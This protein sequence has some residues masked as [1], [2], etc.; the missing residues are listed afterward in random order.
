M[1]ERVTARGPLAWP[2]M[3]PG[4]ETAETVNG[5][6]RLIS[7]LSPADREAL[8]IWALA[9]AALMVLAWASA[10]V[11]RSGARRGPL[12]PFQQWAADWQQNV[13]AHGYFSAASQPHSVAFFPGFPLVLALVHLVLWD[14]VLSELVVSF[15]AGAVAVVALTRLA[16]TSRAAAVLV[17]MPAAVFLMVGYQESLFLA[18][19][20]PAWLAARNER[21]LLAGSLAAAAGLVQSDG[22]WLTV[23]LIVMALTAAGP[24]RPRLADGAKAALGL[25]GPAAYEA[26]LWAATG[27]P[28]AWSRAQQAGWDL[29][30]VAPWRSIRTTWWAAFEHPFGTAYSFE[31]QVELAAFAAVVVAAVCFGVARRWPEMT[32]CGLAAI[33]AVTQTWIVAMPRTM[34]VLFP[35]A[36]A[37]AAWPKRARWAWVGLCGPLTVVFGLLYLAGQ[38]AG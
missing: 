35:I 28:W 7:R 31:F 8:G 22:V 10:W 4:Q 21:W 25:C 37:I 11:F 18:L 5:K 13:A 32:L 38:W 6:S 23:A 27:T 30:L 29:H 17:T 19:A 2:P 16:G 24:W 34:L 12:A 3:P 15:C 9:Y 36:A 14:W 33:A 1:S 26:Y 20:V